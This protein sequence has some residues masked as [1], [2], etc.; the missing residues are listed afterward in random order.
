MSEQEYD[1]HGFRHLRSSH[2]VARKPHVCHYCQAVIPVGTKHAYEAYRDEEGFHAHRACDRCESGVF[3]DGS[4]T[5]SQCGGRGVVE[6]GPSIYDDAECPKCK[7]TGR[8][9]LTAAVVVGPLVGALLTSLP[10][11]APWMRHLG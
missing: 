11:W 2:P 4:E 5:C 1:D 10:Q 6:T 7:G 3:D 8:A 9:S